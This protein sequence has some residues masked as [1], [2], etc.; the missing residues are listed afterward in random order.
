MDSS[1]TAGCFAVSNAISRTTLGVPTL[2]RAL[3]ESRAELDAISSELHSLDGVLDLLKDDASS[4][5]SDMA[6]RTPEVL[7]QC[8]A[9][10]NELGGYLAALNSVRLSK[11]DRRSQWV[12]TRKHMATLR[13]T[14]EAYKSTL[15][16]ALDLVAL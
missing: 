13:T 2:V 11:N 1:I 7:W 12:A 5:P 6:R 16:L 8:T 15:G 14:L 3:R 4:I 10:V 9:V